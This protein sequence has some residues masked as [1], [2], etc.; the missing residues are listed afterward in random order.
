MGSVSPRGLLH[1]GIGRLGPGSEAWELRGLLA[2]ML[3]PSPSS[4]TQPFGHSLGSSVV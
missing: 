2:G 4:L 1:P 3:W